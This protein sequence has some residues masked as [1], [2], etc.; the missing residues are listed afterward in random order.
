MKLLNP[1]LID[2]LQPVAPLL[3]VPLIFT[4]LFGWIYSEIYVENIPLVIYDCDNSEIS[5]EIADKFKS[6]SSFKFI[7]Y[8][9]S[10][11][12]LQE[13]LLEGQAMIGVYLPKDLGKEIQAQKSPK[14]LIYVDNTNTVIGNTAYSY[15]A[16]I[17]N[18]VSA[19]IEM[20]YLA[21]AGLVSYAE[22]SDTI[23]VLGLSER[24]LYNPQLGYFRYLFAAL[25]AIFMQQ[26]YMNTMV[27]KLIAL[28][29][30]PMPK[31]QIVLK[32][33]KYIVYCL[34]LAS[35]SYISCIL[36]AN[37]YFDY[38]IR[39]SLS[40]VLGLLIIFM[41]NMTAICLIL[42][43]CFK[44]KIACVQFVMLL[45]IP[46]FLSCGYPWPEFMMPEYFA[47]FIKSIWPLYYIANPLKDLLLKGTPWAEI[48]PYIYGGLIFTLVWLPISILLYSLRRKISLSRLKQS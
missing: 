36:L 20:Q 29:D 18:T 35:I 32:S 24:V 34:I 27:I 47:S 45:S 1:K 22:A 30:Q 37:Y 10:S 6:N 13:M 25:L 33:L 21:G 31:G 11:Q 38:P 46:T 9:D 23:E 2:I 42:A 4:L 5:R 3:F 48:M 43:T 16:K 41:L 7:R 19:G 15:A 28:R 44:R 12:D 26:T 39:S 8:A 40:S 14:I 17:A